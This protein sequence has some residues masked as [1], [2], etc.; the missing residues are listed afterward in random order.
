MPVIQKFLGLTLLNYVLKTPFEPISF[1][2]A[3]YILLLFVVV[4]CARACEPARLF[5]RTCA[6]TSDPSRF[7]D[8]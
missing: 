2:F 1:L 7:M 3:V 4:C 6:Y 5:T 8:V